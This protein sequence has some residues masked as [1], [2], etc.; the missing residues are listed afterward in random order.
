M[1]LNFFRK[2]ITLLA[3]LVIVIP[4]F[5][6]FAYAEEDSKQ[7]VDN[8]IEDV[9]EKDAEEEDEIEGQVELEE[10]KEPFLRDSK[11]M[12]NP[13]YRI[14]GRKLTPLEQ[15][16]YGDDQGG[17]ETIAL[18]EQKLILVRALLAVGEGGV[19]SELLDRIPQDKI[20]NFSE[21]VDFLEKL[22]QKYGSVTEG[23]NSELVYNIQDD[24][25]AFEKAAAKAYYT[26]YGINEEEQQQ[27]K[28]AILDYLSAKSA[29]TFSKMIEALIESM[30]PERKRELLER[31]LTEI[32][33]EDLIKN[34]NFVAKILEQ[35][36]VTYLN[37]KKLFENLN[38]PKIPLK[39]N[40]DKK[41]DKKGNNVV[42]QKKK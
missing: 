4:G 33:R 41:G 14:L 7:K 10:P 6:S 40:G 39:N 5:G 34:K 13:A 17:I 3:F 1:S 18:R 9:F 15:K 20:K 2:I 27:N 11:L 32:N 26:V 36:D 37:L 38:A 22:I 42:P 8:E 35:Q 12:K 21:A 29:T 28:Q 30:T 25:V 31:T 16:Q 24:Q 19:A 23:I